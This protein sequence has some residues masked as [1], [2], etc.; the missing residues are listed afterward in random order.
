MPRLTGGTSVLQPSFLNPTEQRECGLAPLAI[1]SD[2]LEQTGAELVRRA[3]VLREDVRVS[4][5]LLALDESGF[6][7]VPDAL[8]DRLGV[9]DKAQ[10]CGERRGRPDPVH[11]LG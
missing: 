3:G 2:H 11:D 6:E 10:A 5:V 8:R 7:L 9:V 4:T 1:V